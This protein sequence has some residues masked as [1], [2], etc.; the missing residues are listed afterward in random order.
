MSVTFSIG[1]TKEIQEKLEAYRNE[2]VETFL[3]DWAD[4]VLMEAKRLL[5]EGRIEGSIDPYGGGAFDRGRLKDSGAVFKTTD[6]ERQVI[7]DTTRLAGYEYAK[8]IEYGSAPHMPPVKPLQEWARRNKFSDWKNAGWAIAMKIKKEG[9]PPRPF[10]RQAS[11]TVEKRLQE[12][13]KNAALKF[14]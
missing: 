1:T 3:D 10:L 11:L 7:F 6:E 13:W 12:I 5:R 8:Y 2:I 14:G 9:L 4:A